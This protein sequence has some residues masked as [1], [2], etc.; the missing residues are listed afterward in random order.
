[1]DGVFIAMDCELEVLSGMG[2]N[3]ISWNNGQTTT[4]GP[5]IKTTKAC[6]EC[7]G[8]DTRSTFKEKQGLEPQGTSWGPLQ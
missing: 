2:A 4:I 5:Y 1:M 6:I 8:T 3:G 7:D